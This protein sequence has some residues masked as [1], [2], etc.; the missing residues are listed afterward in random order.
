MFHRFECKWKLLFQKRTCVLR[1]TIKASGGD[2][3]L[4]I[5]CECQVAI[6]QCRPWQLRSL[7][8]ALRQDGERRSPQHEG[9]VRKSE[10]SRPT[11]VHVGCFVGSEVL[12]CHKQGS[13]NYLRVAEYNRPFAVRSPR[14][15]T[16]K[17]VESAPAIR[18]QND[19]RRQRLNLNNGFALRCRED[20]KRQQQQCDIKCQAK[21]FTGVLL[22]YV[23][24]RRH[25]RGFPA[26]ALG[27]R[28][29][30]GRN[31]PFDEAGRRDSIRWGDSTSDPA[32]QALKSL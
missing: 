28:S 19:E 2:V 32:E 11:D 23:R 20:C 7:R 21:G 30:A 3:A 1:R 18:R 5:E 15:G 14:L 12:K 8:H 4:V 26:S 16:H 25:L 9:V 17:Y 10:R 27:P 29:G 13:C 31:Y 22:S 6:G 24:P